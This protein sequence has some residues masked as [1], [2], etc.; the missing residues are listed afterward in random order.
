M[1]L[2]DGTTEADVERWVPTASVLHSNGDAYDFAVR[3]GRIVGVRGHAGDRVNHGRLGPK[4]LFGWQAIGAPDRLRTPLVRRAGELVETDWDTAMGRIVERSR[5][6][7]TSPEGGDASASTPAGS[8]RWRT[9]TPWRSSGR[10]G[11][12]RHT[13][14]ATPACARRRRRP[15]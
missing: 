7:S 11:S 5:N 2:E 13:W 6:C 1:F 10:P 8:W 3:D 9:T 4:D 15:R 14:M 12:A